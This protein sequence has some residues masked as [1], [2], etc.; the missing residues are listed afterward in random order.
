MLSGKS[1]SSKLSSSPTR[2]VGFDA[3]PDAV[4]AESRCGQH[5]APAERDDVATVDAAF[6]RHGVAA[7]IGGSGEGQ[8][9]NALQA[10]SLARSLTVSWNLV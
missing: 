7:S 6:D 1:V 2:R 3:D 8:A 9:L 10:A 5:P 4:A